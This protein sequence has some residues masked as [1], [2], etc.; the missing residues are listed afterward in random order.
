MSVVFI[1]PWCAGK[2]TWGER[3]AHV[4][5][6]QFLDLDSIAPRY[7]A[8][9]GWSVDHLIRRNREVGMLNSEKEWED[10][11]AHIVERVLQDYPDSAISFG[12]SYTGY[13][14][15]THYRRVAR[16]L[17]D[18]SVVLVSP[19]LDDSEASQICRQRALQS[20]GEEWV[21]QRTDFTSWAPTTLDREVANAL[22]VTSDETP[23][24]IM[25]SKNERLSRELTSLCSRAA[26]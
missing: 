25:V 23:K 12:A 8:E 21:G 1:G 18:H 17:Q 11:R 13:T 16:V 3:F 2:S 26:G 10:V 9:L 4:T 6:Q 19:N 15:P 5:G 24:F 7:G 20:R 14:D 22:L